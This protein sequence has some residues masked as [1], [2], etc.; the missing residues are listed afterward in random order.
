MEAIPIVRKL[1]NYVRRTRFQGVVVHPMSHFVLQDMPK[2]D[3]YLGR[4]I[5]LGPSRSVP[6]WLAVNAGPGETSGKGA[7][8][9][10]V[11]LL[12]FTWRDARPT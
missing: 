12:G 3:A 11:G 2:R 7:V 9:K 10:S 8:K 5:T 1:A 4:R 6:P